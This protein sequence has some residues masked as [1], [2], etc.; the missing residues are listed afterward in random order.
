MPD[1]LGAAGQ[2]RV[3]DASDACAIGRAHV[4]RGTSSH[5]FGS[6]LVANPEPFTLLVAQLAYEGRSGPELAYR[7]ERFPGS[8]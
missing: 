3:A 5:S 6:D 4:G 8:A 2:Q 7:F 1:P